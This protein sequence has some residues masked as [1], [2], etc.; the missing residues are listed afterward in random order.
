KTGKM[1]INRRKC[2]KKSC[3]KQVIKRSTR[4]GGLTLAE[5][6]IQKI[7]ESLKGNSVAVTIGELFK[8][9][10][11]KVLLVGFFLAIFMQ[12]SGINTVIDFAPKMLMAAGI[13]I[14]NALLQTSL[15]GLINGLFTFVAITY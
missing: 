1:T 5:I 8:S 9:S 13:E 6:E 14:K 2:L 10:S 7:A 4:I 15:I 3:I 12:I 11:R